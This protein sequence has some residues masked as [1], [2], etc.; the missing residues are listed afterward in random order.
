MLNYC[1]LHNCYI[2]EKQAKEKCRKGKLNQCKHFFK[3][4][5][6]LK[7]EGNKNVSFV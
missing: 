2:K 1:L 5:K 7:K 4:Y 6:P 3:L